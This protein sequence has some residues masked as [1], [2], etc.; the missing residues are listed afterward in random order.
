MR[1]LYEVWEVTAILVFALL[2]DYKHLSSGV[3]AFLSKKSTSGVSVSREAS[4]CS[5]L[6]D[7]SASAAESAGLEAWFVKRLATSPMRSSREAT[8]AM[9]WYNCCSHESS[10]NMQYRVLHIQSLI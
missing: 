5:K 3:E 7:Q 9:E 1:S 2:T 8:V 6:M 4:T 10:E